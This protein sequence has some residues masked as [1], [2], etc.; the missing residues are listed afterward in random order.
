MNN[1][2]LV[3]GKVFGITDHAVVEAG[4]DRQ[5][6]IAMLHGVVGFNGAVHSQHTQKLAITGRVGAQAHQRIGARNTKHIH[7]RAQLRGGIAQQHAAAG[8]KIGALR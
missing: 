5:Q 2:A 3:L 8:I 7:Q 6:H 4:T 1:L